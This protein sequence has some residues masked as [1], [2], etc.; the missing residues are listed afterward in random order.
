MAV[1]AVTQNIYSMT[2]FKMSIYNSSHRANCSWKI[3]KLVSLTLSPIRSCWLSPFL[4]SAR[5]HV[6]NFP[7]STKHL[8]C[9]QLFH[10]MV[11]SGVRFAKHKR[12]SCFSKQHPPKPRE[13]VLLPLLRY[14][15][16]VE[17]LTDTTPKVMVAWKVK[18]LLSCYASL[19]LLQAQGWY[20]IYIFLIAQRNTY[21][22]IDAP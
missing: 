22:I 21:C 20:L 16:T 13:L 7:P 3:I 4:S 1:S 19:S 17:T 5:T 14:W 15:T 2:H 12:G 6:D 18:M 10:K 8:G 11:K 9:R